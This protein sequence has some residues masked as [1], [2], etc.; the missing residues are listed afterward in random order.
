MEKE[1]SENESNYEILDTPDA[2]KVTDSQLARLNTQAMIKDNLLG[3]INTTIS[4]LEDKKSVKNKILEMIGIDLENSQPGEIT[5]PMLAKTYEILSKADNELALGLF[6]LIK[7]NKKDL[8]ESPKVDENNQVISD[9]LNKDD[10]KEV[11]DFLDFMNQ[12]KKNEF[13]KEEK[14]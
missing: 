14:V 3:F 11:K 9:N 8:L 7:N 13:N 10:I 2:E 12:A 1:K 4:H 5:L 6:D